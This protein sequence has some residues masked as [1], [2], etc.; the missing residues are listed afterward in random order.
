M[1]NQYFSVIQQTLPNGGTSGTVAG[2]HTWG[3]FTATGFGNLRIIDTYVFGNSSIAFTAA[4]LSDT[5]APPAIC[6]AGDTVISS[7]G[8][9]DSQTNAGVNDPNNALGAPNNNYA[10][11]RAN[12]VLTLDLTDL[13]PENTTIDI[14]IARGNNN[15]RVTI[16][17][18]N[19]GTN[20]SGAGESPGP[21]LSGGIA[22][23]AGVAGCGEFPGP[24]LSGGIA[25]C[26]GSGLFG[27][28]GG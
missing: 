27:C 5:D 14:R 12:D 11:L 22:G 8:N 6:P 20:F 2:T 17:A 13:V 21:L 16:E 1:I 28:T 25:G 19:D 15:G 18:S 9:A 3:N 10:D 24:E 7:S 26:A 23:V 4:V